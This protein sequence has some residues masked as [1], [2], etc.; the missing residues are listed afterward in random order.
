MQSAL[1]TPSTGGRNLVIERRFILGLGIGIRI[2]LAISIGNGYPITHFYPFLSSIGAS[3][4]PWT[5]WIEGSGR[6]DALPYGLALVLPMW[7]IYKLDSTI[8]MGTALA[9]HHIIWSLTAIVI[10]SYI[11]RRLLNSNNNGAAYTYLFSPIVIYV[12]FIYFQT[13]VLIG[14]LLLIA[15]INMLRKM[16]KNAGLAF[17]AAVGAKFGV[18]ICLPFFLVFLAGNKRWRR[19]ICE[20]FAWSVPIALFSYLP[21]LWSEG[22][23]FMVLGTKETQRIFDL[24]INMGISKFFVFPATYLILIYLLWRLRRSNALVLA[25]FIGVALFALG[26]MTN[27]AIGWNLWGLP[28]ILLISQSVNRDLIIL[29]FL[30]QGTIVVRDIVNGNLR[31]IG[32]QTLTINNSLSNLIFTGSIVLGILWSMAILR[33]EIQDSDTLQ[34]N[35]KPMSL[36]IAGDSGVGK[37]T[38]QLAI[39][40]IFGPENCLAVHGDDYHRFE[41]GDDRWRSTTHLHPRGN[42]LDSWSRDLSLALSRKKFTTKAYDHNNGRFSARTINYSGDLV[43]SQG[44]HAIYGPLGTNVDLRV[45]VE[46]QEDLRVSLKLK[47]DQEA[48]N[49]SKSSVLESIKKRKPDSI[50]YIT[51]QREN[52]DIIFHLS[53]S[54]QNSINIDEILIQ[55]MNQDLA[56]RIHDKVSPFLRF[57]ELE[58]REKIHPEIRISQVNL[59]SSETVSNLLIKALSNYQELVSRKAKIPSGAA[60]VMASVV[61]M[62]LEMQRM[63]EI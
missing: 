51:P 18:L 38:L 61:L 54:K 17:G 63:R 41:R 21:A 52:A 23:R 50:K 33:K 27:S 10:D 58:T 42:H 15:V 62:S 3:L 1:N 49:Q 12:N 35:K 37:D 60:G 14:V 9:N 20:I 48:R 29:L 47:R 31:T 11:F 7:M 22:F 30:I 43:I 26:I 55:F 46:M 44:L 45:F 57:T 40:G 32:F 36:A 25:G 59:I 16:N 24:Q 34:L 6:A 19:D 56:I 4:D 5:H 39:S 53:S 2:A 8:F 28:L 13:D